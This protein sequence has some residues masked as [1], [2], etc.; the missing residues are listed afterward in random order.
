MALTHNPYS[1]YSNTRAATASKADLVVMLYEAA[2]RFIRE[3]SLRIDH[4][5]FQAKAKAVDNAL[6]IV[7]ELKMSISYSYN[8]ELAGN[9]MNIYNFATREISTANIKNQH[10][11]LEAVVEVLGTLKTAWEETARIE[12]QNMISS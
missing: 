4:Q 9:L 8:N 10:G 2:I 11:Q 5:E 3:I 1:S 7:N 12:K 6:A